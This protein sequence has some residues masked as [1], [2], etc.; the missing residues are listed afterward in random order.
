MSKLPS[1]TLSGGGGDKGDG[2]NTNSGKFHSLLSE[3]G[4]PEASVGTYTIEGGRTHRPRSDEGMMPG[5]SS[6]P[7]G[8]SIIH[9]PHF[10]RHLESTRLSQ[11]Q[12][13]GRTRACARAHTR[14][15]DSKGQ[16]TLHE[17]TCLGSHPPASTSPTAQ[18]S[19]DSKSTL[20]ETSDIFHQM[21]SE[22]GSGGDT[23]RWCLYCQI[24]GES[25]SVEKGLQNLR[26]CLHSP[27]T[28]SLTC[29]F[30]Y[31]FRHP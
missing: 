9:S 14:R 13:C 1:V 23:A 21:P 19:R 20:L 26:V 10:P 17:E 28:P 2:W 18:L 11:P 7:Q 6:R 12:A 25:Q 29:H 8:L 16:D 15:R 24:N 22:Q 4:Y 27:P 5:Q 30:T 3:R 31:P